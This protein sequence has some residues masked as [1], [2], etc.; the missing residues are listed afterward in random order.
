MLPWMPSCA[1]E[2][3]WRAG[4]LQ[5]VQGSRSL[6]TVFGNMWG[7]NMCNVESCIFLLKNGYP[8]KFLPCFPAFQY[9]QWHVRFVTL[10][11]PMF[12]GAESWNRI[13]SHADL[14]SPYELNLW[15]LSFSSKDMRSSTAVRPWLWRPGGTQRPNPQKTVR[16]EKKEW[17]S[18]WREK[19]ERK[20]R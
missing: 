3:E 18:E 7:A 12:F 4:G 6:F 1:N 13:R 5:N 2:F 9:W 16:K 8:T 20:E 15:A 14:W 10:L 17:S 19:R 11:F